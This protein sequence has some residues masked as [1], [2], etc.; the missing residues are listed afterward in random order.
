MI[1]DFKTYIGESL[2]GSIRDRVNGD[3]IRKE[4]DI[5]HMNKEQFFE[6]LKDLYNETSSFT[7]YI[8]A[9]D[10]PFDEILV[11]I[12]INDKFNS[13]TASYIALENPDD[14]KNKCVTI[15]IRSYHRMFWDAEILGENFKLK[16]VKE[17]YKRQAHI[18]VYPKDGSPVTNTFFIEVI[19]FLLE[20]IRDNLSRLIKKQK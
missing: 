11:P 4:D 8:K 6:Y 16:T 13:S 10:A 9:Y 15:D 18:K 12:S 19:D 5:D 7:Y 20:H 17:S 14:P 1:P 2:W 3:T